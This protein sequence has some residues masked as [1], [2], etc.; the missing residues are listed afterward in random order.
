M[1]K[2]IGLFI[3]A[4]CFSIGMQAATSQDLN[5]AT[6]DSEILFELEENNCP[7]IP[8]A[9]LQKLLKFGSEEFQVSYLDMCDAYDKGLL[10][11]EQTPMTSGTIMYTL[12][13]EGCSVCALDAEI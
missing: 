3:F 2:Y 8:A 7:C 4:A 9:T 13:F 5:A 12:T 1:L 11:I 10:N 6:L